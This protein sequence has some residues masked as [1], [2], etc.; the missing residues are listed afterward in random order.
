[1]KY[2]YKLLDFLKI[3]RRSAPNERTLVY[4]LFF[5]FNPFA[6]FPTFESLIFVFGTIILSTF[7]TKALWLL[8]PMII[9]RIYTVLEYDFKINKSDYA[10]ELVTL[11]QH[12]HLQSL[13]ERFEID[14]NLVDL[15]YKKQSLLYWA[16]Y[17]NNH[18]ANTMIIELLKARNLKNKR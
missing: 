13:K 15:K 10:R 2:Y 4:Y 7:Y 9:Y 11:I 12:N 16:K 5:F 1:M 8:L 3:Q 14:P 6:F 17:Y 18:R